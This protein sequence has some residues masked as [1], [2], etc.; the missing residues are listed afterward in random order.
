M[1]LA[2]QI[3][4]HDSL[5]LRLKEWSKRKHYDG[6]NKE[7]IYIFGVRFIKSYQIILYW[8][9]ESQH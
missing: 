6:L 4:I 1:A 3:L 8:Y 9:T 2:T 7:F 5:D